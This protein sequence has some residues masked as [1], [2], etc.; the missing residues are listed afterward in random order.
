MSVTATD[1]RQA[2]LH[3]GAAPDELPAEVVTHISGC[4]ACQRF[5]DETRA[6]DGRVRQ[7]LEVPLARFRARPAPRRRFALAASVLLAILAG[8]GVW[9]VRPQTALANEVVR[10]IEHEAA[11][12]EQT[13][14]LPVAEFAEV[15]RQAGVEIDA[16]VPVIYASACPFR[17]HRVPHFVVRTAGGPVTVMLLPH[18]KIRMRTRFSEAGMRGVLVPVQEGS[19]ALVARDGEVPDGL[20]EEIAGG[21]RW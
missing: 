15:L 20:A 16:S 19:V 12:W 6:V 17:G 8:G 21:V 13:R 18:E 11:S 14:V 4:A 9:L 3:I 10:H 5:L 2:R 7:A 1:C